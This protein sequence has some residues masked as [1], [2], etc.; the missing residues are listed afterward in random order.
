MGSRSTTSKK[1]MTIAEREAAYQAARNRIF[2]HFEEKEKAK[3]R[4]TSAS[5][6][7]LSLA[8]ASG[9]GSQSGGAGCSSDIEDNASTAPTESE[10]SVPGTDRRRADDRMSTN[11][12]P[13]SYPLNTP[14]GIQGRVQDH[15]SSSFTFPSLYDPTNEEAK[16]SDQY[17]YYICFFFRSSVAYG[18]TT[19]SLYTTISTSVSS[20][21]SPTCFLCGKR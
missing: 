20:L 9:S 14:N 18:L 13:R 7:T 3:E 10:W 19:T 6:S 16:Y 5:S 2:M 4:D 12:V 21:S 1:R 8:S 15:A 11:D 17:S